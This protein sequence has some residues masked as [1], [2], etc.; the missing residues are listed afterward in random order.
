MG[1]CL[2]AAVVEFNISAK[3]EVED[4]ST[5]KRCGKIEKMPC[6]GVPT[7]ELHPSL[8][9]TLL[10]FRGKPV[11]FKRIFPNEKEK[12]HHPHLVLLPMCLIPSRLR[13][14]LWNLLHIS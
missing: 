9:D 14:C 6:A 13:R 4:V 5:N 7:L 10:G 8:S 1:I 12:F 2:H 11:V 3:I